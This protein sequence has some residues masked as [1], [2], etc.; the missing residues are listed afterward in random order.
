MEWLN[1]NRAVLESDAVAGSSVLEVG[2]WLRLLARCISQENGGV[3]ADCGLWKPERW[4]TL[5]RVTQADVMEA[6]DLWHWEGHDL[7]VHFYPYEKEGEIRAK[8]EGGK[9]GGKAK[10]P[11]QKSLEADLPPAAKSLEAPG[12]DSEKSL[13][14]DLQ[15]AE[16]SFQRK[17]KERKGK[18]KTILVSSNRV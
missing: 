12:E 9:K 17:G 5:V 8:R 2:V 18:E 10:K 16:K 1:L 14:A 3:L 7:H 4:L 13:E 11:A 6:S 15:P